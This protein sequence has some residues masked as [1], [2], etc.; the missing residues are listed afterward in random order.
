MRL[1]V[2]VPYSV[3]QNCP[4]KPL[5]KLFDLDLDDAP[6]RAVDLWIS[7]FDPEYEIYS[8]DLWLEHIDFIDVRDDNDEK[9]YADFM[10]CT[11]CYDNILYFTLISS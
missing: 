9:F 7:V 6:I 8:R 3:D 5:P 4:S 1:C 2:V 10:A 11:D